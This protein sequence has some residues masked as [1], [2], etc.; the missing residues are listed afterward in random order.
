MNHL[1]TD[2]AP[3]KQSERSRAAPESYPPRS[4]PVAAG[5]IGAFLLWHAAGACFGGGVDANGPFPPP[6]PRPNYP[7]PGGSDAAEGIGGAVLSALGLTRVAGRSGRRAPSL[8]EGLTRFDRL[9]L[10]PQKAEIKAGTGRTFDLQVHS[11]ERGRWFSVVGR[12]D[13]TLS[14]RGNDPCLVKQDGSPNRFLVPITAPAEC[15]GRTVALIGTF[16]PAGGATLTVEA[17][18]RIRIPRGDEPEEPEFNLAAHDGADFDAPSGQ[19]L[20]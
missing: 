9:Q 20:D 10:L 4:R 18:V 1:R 8:P 6:V 17:T 15:D 5:A 11:Q 7:I 16:T 14:V 13:A 19:S 12:Q 2:E 3:L